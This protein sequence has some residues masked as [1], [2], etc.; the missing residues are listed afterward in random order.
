MAGKARERPA[1]VAVML[2]QG[3]RSELGDNTLLVPEGRNGVVWV[4]QRQIHPHIQ[5][6]DVYQLEFSR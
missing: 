5:N 2:L 3:P 4:R 1:L 6:A